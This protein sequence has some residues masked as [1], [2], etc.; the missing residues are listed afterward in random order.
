MEYGCRP[1]DQ[2]GLGIEVLELKNKCLLSKWLFK[3]LTEEGM[4]Q[5]LLLNKYVKNKTLAQV[6]VKP[7]DSPFWK[8]LMR[9]KNESSVRFWEDIWLGNVSLAQQYPSLYNIVQRKNVLVATVLAQRPLNISF[10]RSF[11]EGK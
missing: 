4:W 1:K 5:Q 9:V 7:M 6:E 8:G 11:N 3:L 2:R 10:R